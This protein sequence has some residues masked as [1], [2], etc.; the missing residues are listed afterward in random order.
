[1]GLNIFEVVILCQRSFNELAKEK[2]DCNGLE[3]KWGQ[4]ND[5]TTCYH[6]KIPPLEGKE[7]GYS[8]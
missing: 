4:R 1:M 3:D 8:C 6:L 2:S 7:E 5:S